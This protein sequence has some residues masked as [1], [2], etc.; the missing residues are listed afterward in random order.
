MTHSKK[1]YNENDEGNE[2]E[3]SEE[4]ESTSA[5]RN[6]W[7]ELAAIER[8]TKRYRDIRMNTEKELEECRK[9]GVGLEDVMLMN[10][11]KF[12]FFYKY[13]IQF[14]VMCRN[15]RIVLAVMRK[16]SFWHFYVEFMNSKQ[17]KFHYRQKGWH[18]KRN[19]EGE[20]YSCFEQND[21][22]DY[23]KIL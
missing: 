17:T 1:Q 11:N 6:A 8:E 20:I 9:R 18:V 19:Y 14:I 22:G 10:S 16:E 12:N 13:F 3:S 2:D 7:N 4:S 15:F 21:K 23:V 5:L